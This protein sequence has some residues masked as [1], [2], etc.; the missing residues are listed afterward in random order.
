MILR[1]SGAGRWVKCPAS[2]ALQNK[3][4]DPATERHPV[5]LEGIAAHWVAERVM[6]SWLPCNDLEH[7]EP[8]YFLGKAEP[9]TGL[10]IDADM[11]HGVN[12]YVRAVWE[13]AHGNL[14]SL[15]IE[16]QLTTHPRIEKNSGRCDALWSSPDGSRL[17][18]WDFKF[19]YKPVRA[20]ENW[21]A[22]NYALAAITSKTETIEIVI[23]QPRGSSASDPVKTWELSPVDFA[24]YANRLT[25]AAAEARTK[26]PGIKAG[27]HCYKC[28][29]AHA[30]QTLRAEAD[31]AYEIGASP[32][33]AEPSN[34]ELAHALEQND[35]AKS[36]LSARQDALEGLAISRITEGEAI[37]GYE[38]KRGRSNRRWTNGAGIVNTGKLF[39]VDL[40]IK[41]PVS[42]NEAE[43]RGL[44]RQVVDMFTERVATAAKLVR[45]SRNESR[46]IF[47]T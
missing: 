12:V 41:K 37:P 8:R 32:I 25:E 19:G 27:D 10:L 34:A 18:L 21:Q 38:Q 44:P 14:A 43:A 45:S 6:N 9:E 30:C 35:R 42:P 33:P 29:A 26:S 1:P 11:I 4:K 2:A 24:P 36:M 31:T 47:R 17:T 5:T 46:E 39:D 7:V 20:F 28:R 3:F 40:T 15:E 22:I 23:V 13:R 16:K